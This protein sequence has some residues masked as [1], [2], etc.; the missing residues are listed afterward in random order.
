[1]VERGKRAMRT[2][3][4]ETNRRAGASMIAAALLLAAPGLLVPLAAFAEAI[5]QYSFNIAAGPLDQSLRTYMR[6]TGR[7]LLYPAAL[8]TGQQ[9]PA[10]TGRFDPDTALKRLIAGL[11]IR[12]LD[13]GRGVYVLSAGP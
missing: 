10:L 12:V 7:Q 5:D 4:E 11:P 8:V 13:Q 2:R 6:V 9:A 1:M 3:H